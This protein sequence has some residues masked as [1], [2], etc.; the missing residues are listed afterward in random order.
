MV[1]G[2]SG[3]PTTVFKFIYLFH[4]PLF[5]IC[6]GYFLTIPKNTNDLRGF[7]MK[8][9]KRLYIPFVKWGVIF[10]VCHNLLYYTNIYSHDDTI[11][12]GI[13]EYRNIILSL[14]FTMSGQEP[15]IFQLWF[16][17]QLLLASV[18]V[19]FVLYLFSVRD[20][21]VNDFYLL[22]P[23]AIGT[24]FFKR[25]HIIFP[26][27]GDASISLLSSFFYLS[28]YIYKKNEEVF[29]GYSIGI[30]CLF[31]LLLVANFYDEKVEMLSFTYK[32]VVLLMCMGLVGSKMIFSLANVLGKTPA[33]KLLYYIGNNTMLVLIWHLL[34]FKIGNFLIILIW[35]FPIER[36]SDSILADRNY[37]WVLYSIVGCCIPLLFHSIVVMIKNRFNS[38]S[39]NR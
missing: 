38:L 21:K 33:N 13:S 1:I 4:M 28:G 37:F 16:L 15:M 7:S 23:F 8:K 20:I 9:I 36:L 5:F 12:Y 17:K 3:C 34:A 31:V 39:F 29:G 32:N 19:S 10:M 14:L 24:I 30:L 6:S 27:I 22:F 2:H 18:I 35:N 26:V 11:V 25:Y